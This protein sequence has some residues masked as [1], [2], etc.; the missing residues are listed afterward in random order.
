MMHVSLVE[1]SIV[2]LVSCIW[3]MSSSLQVWIVL[4]ILIWIIVV[5]NLTAQIGFWLVIDLLVGL[6]LCI[7]LLFG[8]FRCF[9]RFTEAAS[10]GN[11]RNTYNK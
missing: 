3:N 8:S 10:D 1:V 7:L 6:F 4:S 11:D 9:G 5:L 2:S